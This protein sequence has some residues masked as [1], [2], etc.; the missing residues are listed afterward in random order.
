MTCRVCGR[1]LRTQTSRARGAGPVCWAATN[2]PVHRPVAAATTAEVHPRQ[3][4]L[5][6]PPIQTALTWSS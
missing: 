4:E 3:A 6:L 1:P 2:S 5:P